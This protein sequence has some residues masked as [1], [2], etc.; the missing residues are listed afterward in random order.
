MRPGKGP[1]VALLLVALVANLPLL[2]HTWQQWRIDRDGVHVTAEVTDTDVLRS[3]HYVVR[4]R[5]PEDIDPDRQTWPIE[6][7]RSTYRKAEESGEIGVTVLPD[8]PSAQRVDGER[9]DA[10]GWIVIGAVDLLLVL[11]ALLLWTVRRRMT[12]DV[13]AGSTSEE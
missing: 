11:L 5:L 1:F 4:L 3:D 13:I 6:V 7:D 2:H 8:Q 9:A 10:L 12:S